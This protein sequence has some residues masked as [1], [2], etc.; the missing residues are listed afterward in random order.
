M[1]ASW[2]VPRLTELGAVTAVFDRRWLTEPDLEVAAMTGSCDVVEIDAG[3]DPEASV[4]RALGRREVDAVLTFSEPLNRL[5]AGAARTLGL[6]YHAPEAT[7]LMQRKDLQRDALEAAGIPVPRRVCL[8]S[9]DDL[10]RA[11]HLAFPAVL[12]PVYGFA[13]TTTFRVE[14]FEDLAGAFRVARGS[15]MID[16]RVR[17]GYPPWFLLEELLLGTRWHPDPRFG[18]YVSVESLLQDGSVHHL[19]VSDKFPLAEPFRESGTIAP[20]SLPADTQRELEALAT[21]ALRAV[22]AT[23]GAAHTE[24]KL[25]AEGPR[26]IEVNGRLGGRTAP[27]A[28][29][30]FEYDVVTELA[31]TLLGEVPALPRERRRYACVIRPMTPA[32][33][34]HVDRVEGIDQLCALP[35][36]VCARPGPAVGSTPNWR[37]GSGRWLYAEAVAETIEELLDLSDLVLATA[38][39]V[40]VDG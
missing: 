20:S 5:A 2:W 7:L 26:V 33:D 12:K 28:H 24:L 15:Y 9:A 40:L 4:L 18:D 22:G 30:A 35:G 10:A 38:R 34:V 31:R 37:L 32:R 11:S 14:S 3:E 29:L 13:S 23:D 39:P 1:E 36:V 8:R 17:S 25:T 19:T 27:L 16:P 21:R 6:R